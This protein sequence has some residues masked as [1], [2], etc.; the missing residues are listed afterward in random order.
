MEYRKLGKSGVIPYSPLAGGFLTGQYRQDGPLPEGARAGR[1]RERYL[2]ERNFALLDKMEEIGQAH[3]QGIP[4]VALAWLLTNPLVTAPIV[5]ANSTERLQ[6][7]L[8]A[9]GFRLSEPEMR[10]LNELSDWRSG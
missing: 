5:G 10:M 2:S 1:I 8:A 3:G 6:A 7:S 4:Q 9:A